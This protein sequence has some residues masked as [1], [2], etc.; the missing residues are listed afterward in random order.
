[1][2]GPPRVEQG[3]TNESSTG[4]QANAPKLPMA[5]NHVPFSSSRPYGGDIPRY[6]LFQRQ[7]LADQFAQRD[8]AAQHQTQ[9]RAEQASGRLGRVHCLP[10]DGRGW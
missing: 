6:P 5:R 1:M 7:T 9:G 3:Y 10:I 2:I 4:Q 8:L